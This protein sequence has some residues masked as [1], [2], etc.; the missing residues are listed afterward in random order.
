MGVY[1]G[2]SG[3]EKHKIV[4]GFGKKSEH[5][6]YHLNFSKA[7]HSS[8]CEFTLEEKEVPI[9]TFAQKKA[10][11]IK[12]VDDKVAQLIKNPFERAVFLEVC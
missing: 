5:M 10:A 11:F 6:L 9:F 12:E 8:N 2:N 7:K 1:S 3:I 4:V